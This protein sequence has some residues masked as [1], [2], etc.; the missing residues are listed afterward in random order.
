MCADFYAVLEDTEIRPLFPEDMAEASK[1]LAAFLVGLFG[2]PPLYRDRFG[3]PMMRRRHLHI[4]IDERARQVWLGAF[5]KVLERA[6]L[7][8]RFP[9][10]HLPGFLEFLDAFS[11][12]MVNRAE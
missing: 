3:P 4:P 6:E 10:E 12:W 2:G 11:A 7:D 1:R 8:Y 9:P 5:R